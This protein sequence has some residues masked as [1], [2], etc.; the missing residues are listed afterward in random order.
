MT[1]TH[2]YMID[3]E[4]MTYAKFL[5]RYFPSLVPSEDDPSFGQENNDIFETISDIQHSCDYYIAQEGH[6]DIDIDVDVDKPTRYD[7]DGGLFMRVIPH[8]LDDESPEEEMVC[9]G[10]LVFI[11]DNYSLEPKRFVGRNYQPEFTLYSIP[12]DCPCCP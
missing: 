11:V 3:G 8:H 2:T 7:I 10:V 5:Q 6:E 1:N 12:N 9:V 4:L